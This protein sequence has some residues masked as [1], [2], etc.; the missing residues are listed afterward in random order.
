M[1]SFFRLL[2]VAATLSLLSAPPGTAGQ[3][4]NEWSETARPTTGPAQVYG[5]AAHGCLAGGMSLPIDGPGYQVI[6]VGRHRNFGHPDMVNF[7][8]TLGRRA[9]AAGLPD[10]Y[11]GDM[12]QPRGGPLPF[13]HASHQTGLDVDIWFNLEPKPTLAAMFREDVFLP[14]MVLPDLRRVDPN[15][16]GPRQ[17][18]L[19]RLAAGDPRVD[20]IFVNAAIKEALCRGAGGAGTGDRSWLRR[21]RPWYGHDEHFHVRLACPADSPECEPQTPLP[22]GDGCDATLASWLGRHLPPSSGGAHH[23]A[24]P[25]ACRAVL[26]AR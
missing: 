23:P 17:V 20:R 12:A 15:R 3:M 24:L 9:E 8:E 5:G 25:A 13:G 19:L 1:T 4:S 14:S 2:F 10:F 26:S 6:R 7:V 21:I 11:V 18:E 22:E 16:F